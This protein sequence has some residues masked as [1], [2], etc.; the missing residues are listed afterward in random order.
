MRAA[1]RLV[2][3][4]SFPVATFRSP[5]RHTARTTTLLGA[6]NARTAGARSPLGPLFSTLFDSQ[7]QH[8]SFATCTALVVRLPIN[9]NL[10]A[11]LL[12][13]STRGTVAAVEAEL[14]HQAAEYK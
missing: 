4:H 11:I 7:V 2:W 10:S 9:D 3:F 6:A 14:L 5:P 1:G 12:H 13:A 8:K